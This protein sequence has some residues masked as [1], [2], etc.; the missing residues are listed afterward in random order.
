M[1]SACAHQRRHGAAEAHEQRDERLAAEA[2]QP[3]RIIR[4]KRTARHISAVLEQT[5]KEE[6]QGYLRQKRAHRAE[7][8]EDSP[9]DEIFYPFGSSE[10]TEQAHQS[11]G[12]SAVYKRIRQLA[13]SRA[14]RAEGEIKHSQYRRQKQRHGSKAVEQDFI[15]AAGKIFPA[16]FAFSERLFADAVGKP[17]YMRDGQQFAVRV[18]RL[19]R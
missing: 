5:Q 6:Q 3:Q 14:E 7:T 9:A 4:D 17:I 2:E 15:R 1:Q 18:L 16:P 13:E 10:R 19:V 12:K 11:I 8:R